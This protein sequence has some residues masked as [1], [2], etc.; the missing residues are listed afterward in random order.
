MGS[1]I[2]PDP[3]DLCQQYPLLSSSSCT[4]QHCLRHLIHRLYFDSNSG[5]GLAFPTYTFLHP[6]NEAF[7]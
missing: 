1:I 5:S 3:R 6:K 2:I 4:L 7:Q